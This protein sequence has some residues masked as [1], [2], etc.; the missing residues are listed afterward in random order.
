VKYHDPY[1]GEL[2]PW[3]CAEEGGSEKPK[4]PW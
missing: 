3:H 1:P 2:S 4:G